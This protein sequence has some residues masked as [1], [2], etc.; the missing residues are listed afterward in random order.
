VNWTGG[1]GAETKSGGAGADTLNGGAGHDVINGGDGSDS[2]IGS[3]G[4]DTLN[5]NAGA[6]SIYGGAGSDKLYGSAGADRFIF[7]AVSDSTD[8]SRDSIMDFSHTQ[9]DKI[10]L[11]GIDAKSNVAGDQAFTV[12]SAYTKHAGELLVLNDGDHYLLKG[13]VTGDGVSDFMLNVYSTTKPSGTDF[14]F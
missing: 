2:L 11:S 14:I 1:T 7:K 10:D 13:D 5:G 12:V 4:A 9:G 3:T 8:T 6:D